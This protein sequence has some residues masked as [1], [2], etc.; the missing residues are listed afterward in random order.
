MRRALNNKGEGR[1][2]F[3]FLQRNIS[4][5]WFRSSLAAYLCIKVNSRK[6]KS[7]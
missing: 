6:N 4:P 5:A 2:P 1:S 3:T 7:H